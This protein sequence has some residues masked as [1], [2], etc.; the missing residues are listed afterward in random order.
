MQAGLCHPGLECA[1]TDARVRSVVSTAAQTRGAVRAPTPK[2]PVFC[3]SA[4]A[5]TSSNLVGRR[6]TLAMQ[7]ARS[8]VRDSGGPWALREKW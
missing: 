2:E 3:T 5:E 6:S 4:F 1:V 7:P 8:D